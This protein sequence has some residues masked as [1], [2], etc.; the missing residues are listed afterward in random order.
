M[1]GLFILGNLIALRPTSSPIIRPEFITLFA[2]SINVS[3]ILDENSRGLARGSAAV[4]EAS[5]GVDTLGK[6]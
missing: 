6:S 2:P 4:A 1:R 5:R 3:Q